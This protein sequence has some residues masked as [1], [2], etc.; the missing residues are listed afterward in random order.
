MAKIPKIIHYCWVGGKPKPQSVL[1][2]IESWK[3]FCPDYEIREWNEENYDFT[4]N[5]YMHQAYEAKKWGFVPDYARLDIIYQ[6]GGFYFDTDVEL[7]HDLDDLLDYDAFMG[8]ENTG[9]GEWFVACGL[10]FGAAPGNEV[11][12]LLRDRYDTL[13]FTNQDGSLNLLASPHFSTQCLRQLGLKQVNR[14]QKLDQVMVFASD[15]LGPKNYRTGK[16]E[17]SHRTV[18]IH[19]Y[20]A[21]WV[22]ERIK[23]QMAHQQKVKNRF[24]DALGQK[25]L[26]AESVFQKYRGS[27]LIT[28]LPGRI[29]EKGKKK[30]IQAHEAL[31][32]YLG[33][34]K[35]ASVSPG[36][37]R[38]VLLDTALESL[39]SGDG[40]IMDCCQ[41]QLGACMDISEAAHVST[42]RFP[43]EE[44]KKILVQSKIKILCGTNLLSGHMRHYGLWKLG[45][46][47]SP[48]RGTILMGAGFDSSNPG[49]DDYS[50]RLFRT[51]LSKDG[52]HSVRDSFSEQKLRAM[53]IRNVVNTACPTMWELTPDYCAKI[54][55]TK[56]DRVVTTVTDY[57]RDPERDRAMLE[58]LL[59]NYMQVFLWLQGSQDGT[60]IEQFG[61]GD[62]LV[63]VDSSL[64]SY[65]RLLQEENLDYVGTRLHAGIRAM[66]ALHRSLIISIDNRAACISD[67]TGLPTLLRKDVPYALESKLNASWETS[68]QLPRENIERWKAQFQ[69]KRV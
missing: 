28:K 56:A 7:I 29:A 5:H 43:T 31:P 40:I 21:S 12:R 30:L 53:G 24:G 54:P 42:H 66:N 17:C 33:L 8:F 3:R 22:D 2:C 27:E 60:Y 14:D 25:V 49:F 18:S 19:H 11:I 38:P 35:A 44:E 47:V 15:V 69:V 10:G 13:S 16:I 36:Q 64:S 32:Y 65:D 48:Y 9:D 58:I 41:R 34:M 26:V 37:G 62:R 50:M 61:V 68:L 51:I 63:L 57:K 46:D 67:D 20:S 52:L 1:Y 59:N 39:N 55:Q 23:Q 4:K 45:P 6:H